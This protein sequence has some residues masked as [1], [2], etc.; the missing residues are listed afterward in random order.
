M[1]HPDYDPIVEALHPTQPIVFINKDDKPWS[2][3]PGYDASVIF[4]QE[5][6]AYDRPTWL[7]LWGARVPV[8]VSGNLCQKHGPC[9][10]AARYADEGGDAIPADRIVLDPVPLT[11]IDDV[12]ITRGD[13]ST[14]IGQLYLR[15]G[16]YVLTVSDERGQRIGNQSV[17]VASARVPN[18]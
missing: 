12:K 2:L 8:T 1:N 5:H 17:K 6:F 13:Y 18:P 11:T 7:E 9:M 10:V 4:P 15:P 3:R 16:N 14:P